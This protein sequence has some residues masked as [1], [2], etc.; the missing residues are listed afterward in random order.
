MVKVG[1]NWT[2]GVHLPLI[3]QMVGGRVADFVEVLIDNFLHVEPRAMAEALDGVPVAFHIMHSR[4]MERGPEDLAFMAGRIRALAR[5]LKPIYISDHLLRFSIEGRELIYLPELDYGPAYDGARRAVLAWQ[6]RLESR[7][8]FEN[9]PSVF[10]AGHEQP[11]F[12]ESL[13]RDTGAGL[14]FDISNAVCA[15]RNCGLS[16]SAWD[17][18]VRD[19]EHFHVA[20]YEPS[21]EPPFVT[22]DMHGTNLADDT[23]AYTEHALRVAWH[24]STISVE[25]DNNVELE[26]W[27]AD[28][29]AVRRLAELS[30]SQRPGRL[31]ERA[32]AP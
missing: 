13:L 10:D 23:L 30:V 16:L 14:L 28:L 15:Q 8:L 22:L 19:T 3:Q 5:E 11:A 12:L 27:S 26:P 24:P 18:L 9:Y 2:R 29:S 6:D 25:R 20:G 7:V 17:R 21:T 32:H 1:V 4:F 31:E